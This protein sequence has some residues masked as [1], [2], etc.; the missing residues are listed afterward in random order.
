MR[1]FYPYIKREYLPSYDPSA[2]YETNSNSYMNYL[3]KLNKIIDEFVKQLELMAKRDI[4]VIDTNTIDL[5]K[6]GQWVTELKEL[7]KED[8]VIKLQAD[9]LLSKTTEPISI[10][11]LANFVGDVQTLTNA[12]K[13]KSDGLFAKDFE[14]VLKQLDT[15]LN[16]LIK[17]IDDLDPEGADINIPIHAQQI[18]NSVPKPYKN[19]DTVISSID[20]TKFNMAFITDLHLYPSNESLMYHDNFRVLEQF[21][22]LALKSD[23]AIHCGDNVDSH[24]GAVAKDNDAMS[25]SEVKLATTANMKRFARTV[26]TYPEVP[27]LIVNGNHD[28][29]GIPYATNK[30]HD[31]SMVL[32]KKEIAEITGQPLY[33]GTLFPDK[34]IGIFKIH[35]DD[36]S[37]QQANGYFLETDNQV[38]YE[39]GL[40]SAA[41]FNSLASFMNTLPDGY[42]LLIVG[43]IIIDKDHTGNGT[44]F[45]ELLNAYLKGENYTIPANSLVGLENQSHAE[46]KFIN[47]NNQTKPF[48]G[49]LAG[50]YHAETDFSKNTDRD[51]NMACLLNGFPSKDQ[52]GTELEGTFYN[53]EI[54]TVAKT[55]KCRGIGR[56]TD[57]IN[58]TY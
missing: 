15:K 54:D 22:K 8:S 10:K 1:N 38:G 30:N 18:S 24:S 31:L 6:I 49:Y 41:Q 26:N 58:W 39:A 51:F 9:V 46:I 40:I 55:L 20:A 50:H 36:F 34:K 57:F 23:V 5:T 27:T 29:G 17:R 37:E 3:G 11:S 28:R 14:S 42:H 33:G 13:A 53:I 7:E 52:Q 47:K 2:D 21:K 48:I 44:V 12:I 32:S 19:L 16:D 25:P 35:S 45:N 43:H 4:Q 56:A